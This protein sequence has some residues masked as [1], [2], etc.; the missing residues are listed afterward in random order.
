[1]LTSSIL[2]LNDHK[3]CA[4]S[5]PRVTKEAIKGNLNLSPNDFRSI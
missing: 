5:V 4:M 1:M 2:S 3:Q